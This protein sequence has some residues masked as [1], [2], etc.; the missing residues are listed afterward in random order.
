MKKGILVTSFG[1]SNNETRI[2]AIESMENKVKELYPDYIVNRAFTSR[3]V[4]DILKKRDNYHVD[5]P[6]KA[7]ERM[8]DMDVKEIIILPLLI[9]EGHE[10]EKTLIDIE[11][12][13]KCNMDIGIKV[14]KPLLS[15]NLDF[16][17]VADAL[18]KDEIV[19]YM[20]HGSD[21]E[22]DISYLRLENTIRDKGNENIFIATV[23]GSRGIEDIVEVLKEKAIKKVILRPFMLVAGVHALE[24]MA[25][26]DENSWKSILERN[27]IE[28]EAEIIGLGELKEFQDIFIRH[29]NE[30]MVN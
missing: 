25:S 4:I 5:N 26:D 29:L 17:Q 28:C 10:Y 9:I 2:K 3:M 22:T 1:T 16:D 24:D 19:V 8:K 11:E 15:S 21:H 6:R 12:F 14:A 13:S 20:G 23:E 27:G 18:S 30:S 7:L